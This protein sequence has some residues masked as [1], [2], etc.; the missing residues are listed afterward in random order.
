VTPQGRGRINKERA[1][2]AREAVARPL[3]DRMTSE[4]SVGTVVVG[5]GQAGLAT[6]Y[7][8]ARQ[9]KEFLILEA[10]GRTGDSWRGRWDSLRLFTPARHDALPGMP[11]PADPL[12]FP[13]KDE[14]AGYFERFASGAG[15]PTR[16][17]TRVTSLT[18][19][20]DGFTLEAG[21]NRF[22]AESVVVATGAFRAPVVPAF[23]EGLDPGLTRFHS[24]EYRNPSQ[25]PPGA[26]LVVG[27]GNSGGEIALE[28]ARA[29][30][31]VWLSGR[32]VGR[33]PA[34]RLGS[35]LS[36]RP[37]WWFISRVLSVSTPL[38]RKVRRKALHQGTPWIRMSAAELE[39]VGVLRVPRV[40]GVTEGRPHLEDGR[41]MD[42][43]T[44]VWATGLRP[45]HRW[46]HLPVF[47]GEGNPIHRRGVATG[48]PGLYFV[49]LHFQSAL[50]SSLIGGV[51]RDAEHIASAICGRAE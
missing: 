6:A 36:G 31:R 39:A 26:V 10:G 35:V 13:T 50:T 5:G 46:I 14:A 44:V 16:F 25:V 3:E 49:G 23:A 51:S 19:E 38:G 34:E 33:I 30:R 41:I 27:A 29:G 24:V 43:G 8:L 47:D 11:F 37:Y 9:G 21:T 7:Y 40:A 2:G 12:H 45:D 48:P 17:N 28:L 18:R 42:V 20:G 1:A 4:K 15:Y 22:R 32:D